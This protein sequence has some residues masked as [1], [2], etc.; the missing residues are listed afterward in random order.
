MKRK[1]LKIGIY[2]PYLDTFG[3]GEKYILTIADILSRLSQVDIL[4]D[5]HLASLPL[6]D[7][8][9]KQSIIHNINLR[10][11]QLKVAPMGAGSNFFQRLIYLMKYDWIIYN[12]DG[13]LF[14]SSA[15]HNL[16]HFQVP[17]SLPRQ[18]SFWEKLK[19]GSWDYQVFNSLFTKEVISRSWRG[20]GKVIY[21]PVDTKF[22][23]KT[24]KSKVIVNVGR[25]VKV[26]K[27]DILI[28]AFKKFYDHINDDEWRLNLIGSLQDNEYLN[29]LKKNAEGYPIFF[30][31]N[32]SR[33]EIRKMYGEASLYWHAMGYGEN[34]PKNQEHF[35]I[36]TAE[37]MAAGVVPVVINAGGQPEIVSDG[38][39]GLL[40]ETMQ[41]LIDKSLVL[42]RDNNL[43]IKLSNQATVDVQKFSRERFET[44][45][46]SVVY[47][48][49]GV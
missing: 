20:N 32:A 45:I 5:S 4:L 3:G 36:A 39:N 6:Q 2:S 7:V 24:K 48:E 25:F 35:G 40:W 34:D 42:A 8:L 11:M 44:E 14:Y 26:K 21:P 18:P 49:E 46:L 22:F 37:A 17:F 28:D 13:S 31:P 47:P 9:E 33:E 38:E 12:T 19:R 23:V 41:E 27:Q 16:I 10:N 29:Y 15:K 30:Y 1:R 43:L